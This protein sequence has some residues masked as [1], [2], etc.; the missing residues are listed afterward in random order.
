[1]VRVIP[2]D[3]P[4][5]D[6]KRFFESVEPTPE[7]A[8]YQVAGGEVY[9]V[10]RREDHPTYDGWTDVKNDRR[11]DLIDRKVA[12]T[13]TPNEET[14]FGDLQEQ[15]LR[16]RDKVAPRPLEELRQLHERLLEVAKQKGA[17]TKS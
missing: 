2:V 16:Y 7:G 6:L 9:F 10:K 15:M 14:E 5:P 8:V 13:I 4:D 3:L 17:T 12:G 11:A 1:M